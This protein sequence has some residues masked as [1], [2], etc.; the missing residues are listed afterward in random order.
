MM[1]RMFA[2]L[3]WGFEWHAWFRRAGFHLNPPNTPCGKQVEDLLN[4]W[5]TL[6]FQ[7]HRTW[8]SCQMRKRCTSWTGVSAGAASDSACWLGRWTCETTPVL[9]K[10]M[11]GPICFVESESIW[12]ILTMSFKFFSL[13]QVQIQLFLC[14]D[15]FNLRRRAVRIYVNA[16]QNRFQSLCGF[17]PLLGCLL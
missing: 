4:R 12:E 7:L 3:E 8:W 9:W 15:V 2:R 11:S 6:R 14:D 16:C 10:R 13:M 17:P 1:A 5:V